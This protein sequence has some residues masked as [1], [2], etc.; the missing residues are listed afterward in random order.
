MR[1]GGFTGNVTLEKIFFKHNESIFFWY[2]SR[3]LTNYFPKTCCHSRST[4]LQKQIRFV[5]FNF[6]K[7]QQTLSF[8]PI[9][10]LLKNERKIQFHHHCNLNSSILGNF[11]QA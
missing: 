6:F 7:N 2:R 4:V 3:H 1:L 10:A 5:I 8:I 11:D 9:C